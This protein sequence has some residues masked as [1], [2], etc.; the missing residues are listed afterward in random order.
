MISCMVPIENINLNLYKQ[1]IKCFCIDDIMIYSTLRKIEIERIL[2]SILKNNCGMNVIGYN[3]CDDEYWCKIM[4]NNNVLSHFK[5]QLIDYNFN[6]T[7]IKIIPLISSKSSIKKFELALK[8][9]ILDYE[10]DV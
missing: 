6:I 1:T 3:K 2:L 5:L 8:T 7:T 9:A 4:K 10:F